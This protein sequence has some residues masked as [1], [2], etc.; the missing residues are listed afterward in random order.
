MRKIQKKRVV[1]LISIGCLSIVV[2][3][4]M[5]VFATIIL[6]FGFLMVT[7]GNFMSLFGVQAEAKEQ[8]HEIEF[9]EEFYPLYVEAQREFR[10]N[11][12]LLA[13]LHFVQTDFASS[14]GWL[15]RYRDVYNLPN[16]I[17]DNYQMSRED[18]WLT[19][20]GIPED[21]VPVP[22][23]RNKAEDIIYTVANY[24]KGVNFDDEE[25]EEKIYEITRSFEKTHMV[26]TYTW[27][28]NTIYGSGGVYRWPLPPE[29]DLDYLT[30]PYGDR[31]HPVYG[32]V[33]FHSGIDL[34]APF[35]TPIFAI[36]DG[37]VSY[38]GS[39]SGYG[40]LIIIDHGDGVESWYG[41]S[42]A[43]FVST[44]D[45][46]MAG[47]LIA[48]VGS[49]GTSTG[50]HLHI[51]IRINGN[52]VDPLLYL[53]PPGQAVGG[54]YMEI[55]MMAAE[56]Y[57]VDAALIAAMIQQESGW[58]PNARSP[59]GASGLM[60]IMPFNWASLGITD[61]FDPYQNI[62][63]GTR[64]IK[65]CYDRYLGDLPRTLACYNAG[66]NA[67]ERALGYDGSSGYRETLDYVRKVSSYYEQ[68]K[69]QGL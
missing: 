57:G 64:Y 32:T 49:E 10:V 1:K 21:Y 42:Q 24:F 16:H 12:G 67:V 40:T 25:W 60:Q 36:E 55:V 31:I 65:S 53:V 59:M 41:H 30:S 18:Y 11:W 61:P 6:V 50:A 5:V 37:I 2:P 43:L 52:T 34:G 68:Y 29:Y 27:L 39:A 15:S 35:G 62:M 3:V 66:P 46:V 58:N 26:K 54:D 17:W 38:S 14:T 45:T 28:Y 33:I 56:M 7:T 13:A 69:R 63:G 4:V 48:E 47:Q 19:K 8:Q 22:P 44:G 51:E 20:Y 23:N 9:P